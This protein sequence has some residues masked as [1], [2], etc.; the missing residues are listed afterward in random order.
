MVREAEQRRLFL[1]E[2][3]PDF[4]TSGILTID[5]EERQKT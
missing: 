5:V 4:L 3:F 1:F 2:A